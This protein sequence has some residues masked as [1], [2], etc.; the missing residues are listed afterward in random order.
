MDIF[1]AEMVRRFVVAVEKIANALDHKTETHTTWTSGVVWTED[2]IKNEPKAYT[3][4]YTEE[5]WNEIQD[6]KDRMWAEVGIEPQ[7]DCPFGEDDKCF[8]CGDNT[9][10][11]VFDEP[12]T[13]RSE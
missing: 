1:E 10:C 11:A 8:G 9:K 5:E 3:T 13:E 6:W 12:Q 7:T 2:A 4:T